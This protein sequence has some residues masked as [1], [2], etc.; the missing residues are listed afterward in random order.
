M[1]SELGFLARQALT[2]QLVQRFA[3]LNGYKIEPDLQILD[4]NNP[5]IKMWVAM[6]E[7]AIEEVEKQYESDKEQQD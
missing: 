1:K 3:S 7:A 4:A 5:R 6:A 2:E